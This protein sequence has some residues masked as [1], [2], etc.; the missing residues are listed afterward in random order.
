MLI[1]RNTCKTSCR[2]SALEERERESKA[3]KD[4]KNKCRRRPQRAK[5][6]IDLGMR[7]CE[8]R[9]GILVCYRCK[10]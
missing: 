4:G 2:S 5:I 9:R 10:G 1:S 6:G 8:S 7:E 3:V